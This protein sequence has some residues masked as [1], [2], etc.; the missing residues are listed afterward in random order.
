MFCEY[1]LQ[2]NAKLTMKTLAN[3][4]VQHLPSHFFIHGVIR[5]KWLKQEHYIDNTLTTKVNVCICICIYIYIYIYI[6]SIVEIHK[7]ND[8]SVTTKQ[9]FSPAS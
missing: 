9:K 8:F 6:F 1:N 5:K 4:I 7:D 2:T 3:E